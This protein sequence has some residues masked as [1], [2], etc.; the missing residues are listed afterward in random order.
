MK[1]STWARKN[2]ISYRTA[3]N[4]FNSGK[5]PVPV[6]QTPSGT[7]LVDDAAIN[8]NGEYP[9]H[10][11]IYASVSSSEQKVNIDKQIARL[12]QYATEQNWD[13]RRVVSEVD[14]DSSKTRPQLLKLLQSPEVGTIVVESRERLCQSGF[15]YIEA[16]LS[17]QGRRIVVVERT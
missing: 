4:W 8:K 14:S 2:G 3:W 9:K 6:T 17:A 10:V 16:A 5:M 12:S 15:E 11:T 7:I 1:L 13:V